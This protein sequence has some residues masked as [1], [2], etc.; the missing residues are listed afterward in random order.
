MR[1]LRTQVAADARK[2][3]LASIIYLPLLLARS[4]L[5]QIMKAETATVLLTPVTPKRSTVLEGDPDSYPACD[6]GFALLAAPGSGAASDEPRPS[7][8]MDVAAVRARE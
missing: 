6:R 5:D 4:C 2:L 8:P 3:F 1:F 7:P